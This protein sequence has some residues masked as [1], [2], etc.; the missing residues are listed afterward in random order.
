M[1]STNSWLQ[2]QRKSDLVEIA[3]NVGLKDVDG[4]RKSDLEGQLD[5]FLAE[6]AGR[7]STDSKL[8]GYYNSRARM[9]GSP[10]KK[11]APELKVSKRRAT[12]AAEE[13]LDTP[14]S[15]EE[16]SR[17]ASSAL[18]RTPGRALSMAR[19]IPL[20]ATPNDVAEAVDRGTLA[21]RE[22]VSSLYQESGISEATQATRETLSTVNSV[23][24]LVHAFELWYLRAEVLPNRYV[25]TIPAVP[26]L[27]ISDIPVHL[28][29]M[30]QV[31]TWKFWSPS[32]LY[33]LTAVIIPSLFGYFINLSAA[34]HSHPGRGRARASQ[35]EHAVDP[36][37]FSIVKALVTFVVYNQGVTFCGWIDELS[38]ARVNSAVY[39]GWKGVVA[40]AAITGLVAMY[41]A[42][43]RK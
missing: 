26:M 18:I 2:R 29:D 16:A 8:S 23:L 7:F 39:G 19:R 28:P 20:P 11:E 35:P 21:V 6:H 22:R 37:T 32:L 36:L 14:E 34:N 15:E 4:L 43:L 30:F 38:V 31:L 42:V 5:D 1:S 13:I 41:D 10:V 3:Q 9:A 17:G 33:A 40:G 12:K 24:L 27:G 25:F